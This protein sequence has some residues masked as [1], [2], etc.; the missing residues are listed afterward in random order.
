MIT[1]TSIR[2]LINNNFEQIETDET[3]KAYTRRALKGLLITKGGLQEKRRLINR[4]PT[5]IPATVVHRFRSM[6]KREKEQTVCAAL[7]HWTGGG[8]NE[9]TQALVDDYE[10]TWEEM[11]VFVKKHSDL[12]MEISDNLDRVIIKGLMA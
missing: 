4:Y 12:I 6:T 11:A 9:S 1:D 5:K 8:Y 7:G 10:L 3:E 2:K